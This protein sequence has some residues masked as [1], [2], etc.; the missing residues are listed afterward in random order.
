[1]PISRVI[2]SNRYSILID[3]KIKRKS[4][5]RLYPKNLFTR[6]H[7]QEPCIGER[8][9]TNVSECGFKNIS[10]NFRNQETEKVMGPFTGMQFIGDSSIHSENKNELKQKYMKRISEE[11]ETESRRENFIKSS[12]ARKQKLFREFSSNIV[13][14]NEDNSRE[15]MISFVSNSTNISNKIEDD[16]RKYRMIYPAYSN[17]LH[18]ENLYIHSELNKSDSLYFKRRMNELSN[19]ENDSVAMLLTPSTLKYYDAYTYDGK[20]SD[21]I[22]YNASFEEYNLD[23]VETIFTPQQKNLSSKLHGSEFYNKAASRNSNDISV[24]KFKLFKVCPEIN[25]RTIQEIALKSNSFAYQIV[26]EFDP[27]LWNS[28]GTATGLLRYSEKGLEIFSNKLQDEFGIH[29]QVISNIQE[30]QKGNKSSTVI[31]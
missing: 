29:I 14:G 24:V 22:N 7:C 9:I 11:K 15:K 2:D 28:K 16:P 23:D 30:E 21:S 12:S 25:E 6:A 27:V 31:L 20:A 19:N 13:L 3:E 10:M 17:I 5:E 26:L 8:S 4:I 18:N 1:M